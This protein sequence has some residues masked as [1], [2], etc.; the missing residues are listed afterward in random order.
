MPNHVEAV[1]KLFEAQNKGLTSN[2]H[3]KKTESMSRASSNAF[4]AVC[5]AG[6]QCSQQKFRHFQQHGD[7]TSEHVEQPGL[8]TSNATSFRNSNFKQELGTCN[9]GKVVNSCG[10][11]GLNST[12]HFM[13]AVFNPPQSRHVMQQV[14]FAQ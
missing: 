4:T 8:R 14:V 7:Q 10:G 13:C 1:L 11:G 9:C 5:E 2:L 12:W 6:S 3:F